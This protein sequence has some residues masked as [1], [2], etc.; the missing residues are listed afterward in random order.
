MTTIE[1]HGMERKRAADLR[2]AI[3]DRF[4][5]S[6]FIENIRV[7]VC[8]GDILDYQGRDSPFLRLFVSSNKEADAVFSGLQVFGLEIQKVFIERFHSLSSGPRF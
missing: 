2:R 7:I 8:S 1:I 4:K 5:R 3:F 6:S